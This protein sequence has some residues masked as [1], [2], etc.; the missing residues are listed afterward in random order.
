MPISIIDVSQNN[1]QLVPIGA[2]MEFVRKNLKYIIVLISIFFI[3]QASLL[4]Y[5][6]YYE[7]VIPEYSDLLQRYLTVIAVYALLFSQVYNQ[8]KAKRVISILLEMLILAA[9]VSLFMIIPVL[10]ARTAGIISEEVGYLYI[11]EVNILFALFLSISVYMT[12][13]ISF[14][15]SKII[16][17]VSVNSVFVINC[18]SIAILYSTGFEIGPTVFL[19]FSWEAAKVGVGDNIIMFLGMILI[20][21]PVNVLFL[22]IMKTHKDSI[23]NYT[24]VCLAILAILV[25]SLII[26]FDSYKTKAI[27]PIYSILDTAVRYSD[28]NL[29]STRDEYNALNV[30]D[31]EIAVLNQLG[32]NLS[33]LAKPGKIAP[34]ENKKN[35]ITIYLESFQLNF[36]RHGGDIYPGLSPNINALSDDYVVYTNFINSV[37]PTINAM[38]SS[39]C[40]VDIILSTDTFVPE[41]NDILTNDAVAKDL[42]EDNLVCLSDILHDSGYKQVLMKGAN[43]VFSGK[44]KFFTAHE[45]DQTLGLYQLND[46]DKYTDLNSWGLQDPMLFDEAL[47][48]LD[49]LKDQQPFNLTLLTVNSHTPGFEYS[50]CPVYEAGNSLLN[51]IHCTDYAL[52]QFLNKLEKM[53]VYKNTVV[54]I[55]GDHVMFHAPAN[56]SLLPR[57]P[58]SWYGRTYLAIR[59]PDDSLKHTNDIFGITPDLAPTILDLLGFKNMSF[60]SGNSLISDR[61]EHQR[62]TANSFD[63]INGEM[64]PPVVETILSGC[65]IAEAGNERIYDLEL[66]SECERAKIYYLQQKSVYQTLPSMNH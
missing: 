16:F 36:T 23:V 22:K 4:F 57:M 45:Y 35:I 55:V 28:S 64:S 30:D 12:K 61:R 24:V 56:T 42:L 49:S 41:N 52:G 14:N 11:A 65:S 9:T 29:I 1:G 48:M 7:Y 58:L 15:L 44:G 17:L 46:N 25:N 59:S 2:T 6:K 60:I 54:V 13:Y 63:I 32:I 31:Q 37:T 38:I 33:A 18:I 8:R 27:L 50:G 40:G 3:L 19:H 39:Q 5:N 66:Y 34:P 62:I 53:D 51:G 47:N 10:Y 21:I 20:L 26:N 43:I